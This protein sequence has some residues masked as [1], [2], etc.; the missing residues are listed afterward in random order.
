MGT[1]I[2]LVTLDSGQCVL[3]FLR[4]NLVEEN[5]SWTPSIISHNFLISHREN[6]VCLREPGA[7]RMMPDPKYANIFS[8]EQ[9]KFRAPVFSAHCN[10]RAS[11]ET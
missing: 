11:I 6:R 4:L 5:E 2:H 1:V 8:A 9:A 3:K 7:T 10:A